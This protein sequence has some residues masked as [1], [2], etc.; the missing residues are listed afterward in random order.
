MSKA[1]IFIG[2]AIAAAAVIMVAWG[3]TAAD[4]SSDNG[5]SP[6]DDGSSYDNG[7]SDDGG[8]S[9]NSGGSDGGG[10]SD[11]GGGSSDGSSDNG[12]GS[13]DDG[14]SDNGGGSDDEGS[15]DDGSGDQ[16]ED[17]SVYVGQYMVY[18]ATGFL[19]NGTLRIETIGAYREAGDLMVIYSVTLKMPF[20]GVNE[21]FKYPLPSDGRPIIE[22][23]EEIDMGA[24]I[25][26][27]KKVN[28]TITLTENSPAKTINRANNTN[29]YSMSF[30]G[31]TAK[32]WVGTS[33]GIIYQIETTTFTD[34][35]WKLVETNIRI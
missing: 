19:K 23:V 16:E 35:T 8:S 34:L 5:G 32:V 27:N 31:Q 7:N 29:V 10:S 15:D 13:D 21:H 22:L 24:P 1:I 12:G 14:S 3:L 11:N 33:D 25:S 4:G 9:D 28:N 17:L 30:Y 20:L 26:V 2:V 6:Y 18:K